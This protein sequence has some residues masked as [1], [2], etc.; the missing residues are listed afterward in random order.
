[1][2]EKTKYEIK[3]E[4]RERDREDQRR[5]MRVERIK[6]SLVRYGILFVVLV[7]VGYGIILLAR[8]SVPQGEDFS[9]AYPI[10]GRDHIA[11]GSTHPEYSSNPPSSG[12]HYA[13]PTRG[14]FYNEVVDDETVV[15]NLEHGD[16][17]IAY[18]PRVS[19]EVKSNLEKFAG[20]Y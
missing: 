12:S 17:W 7:L 8:S 9:I 13:Q 10:Q 3:R 16:I 4:K 6:K 19:N 18:H 20:R 15:H 11:F 14:G 2:K 1:M 5:R